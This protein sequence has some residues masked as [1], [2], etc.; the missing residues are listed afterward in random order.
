M[1]KARLIAST[2]KR[3]AVCNGD[4]NQLVVLRTAGQ[5]FDAK[6][7][8]IVLQALPE[9]DVLIADVTPIGSAL[10]LRAATP[11]LHRGIEGAL[12]ADPTRC[13]AMQG[14]QSDRTRVRD[15]RGLETHLKPM[16]PLV[17]PSDL[18]RDRHSRVI[19]PARAPRC[20][21]RFW[22]AANPALVSAVP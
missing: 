2:S 3:H 1:R 13:Q 8:A 18:L 4:R 19:S 20:I 15:V 10:R 7:A 17:Y 16:R 5:V 14:L 11:N 22:G 21:G 12:G 6:G 9:A